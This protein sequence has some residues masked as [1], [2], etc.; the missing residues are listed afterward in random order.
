MAARP[1]VGL[2]PAP[3]AEPPPIAPP[4]AINML[5]WTS[6]LLIVLPLTAA[7]T[8]PAIALTPPPAPLR[9]DFIPST[10]K[11]VLSLVTS[12]K[13]VSKLMA[14]VT[15]LPNQTILP[16]PVVMMATIRL[17]IKPALTPVSPPASPPPWLK[18]NSALT[19]P[20]LALAP[21]LVK[22]I[23]LPPTIPL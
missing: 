23:A 11:T 21:M 12:R 2:A 15:P 10:A 13:L 17:V 4:V 1:S 7:L 9:P 20:A 19:P 3:T 14:A 18:E 22:L 6:A 16:L 8:P 5:G